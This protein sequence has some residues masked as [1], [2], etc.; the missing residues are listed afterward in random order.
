MAHRAPVK[1]NPA[2][3]FDICHS[4]YVEC[5][6]M[7][8]GKTSTIN[9]MASIKRANRPGRRPWLVEYVADFILAGLWALSRRPTWGG[10]LAVF[11]VYYLEQ[12]PYKQAIRRVRVKEGTFDRWMW[13]VRRVVGVELR[14]R[15]IFPPQRYFRER[16]L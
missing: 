14:R 5:R 3:V 8:E 6:A 2:Q 12:V 4:R 13:E 10:R 7:L 16:M 9:P 1:L 11:R 15:G